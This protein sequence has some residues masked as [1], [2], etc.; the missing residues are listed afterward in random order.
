MV[1]RQALLGRLH[2]QLCLG[3][4]GTRQAG[5]RLTN[6]ACRHVAVKGVGLKGQ[7]LGVALRVA[8]VKLGH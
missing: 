4:R 2:A 1:A 8:T 6:A 3:Q 7:V 5:Q